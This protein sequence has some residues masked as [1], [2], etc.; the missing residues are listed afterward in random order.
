[1]SQRKQG[2]TG[3]TS[4]SSLERGEYRAH[5]AVSGDAVFAERC[6]ISL[7]CQQACLTIA[8]IGHRSVQAM[9]GK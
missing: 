3:D 1:M 9:K 6:L 5:L 2:C 4:G 7:N 8:S